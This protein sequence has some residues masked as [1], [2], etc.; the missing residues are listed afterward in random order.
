MKPDWSHLDKYRTQEPPYLSEPGATYGAFVIPINGTHL[1]VIA[2]D[3]DESGDATGQWEHVSTH[4][5]DPVF[6]TVR[7]PKWEE[8]CAVKELFW[9]DNEVV[10]QYHPAKS[11]YVNIHHH[12]LHL[13][14]PKQQQIPTP[15]IACV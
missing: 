7:T 10:L 9:E 12:V 8:M 4:A 15:P 2:T 14:R 5:Y 6:K 1:R 13:W 3:G 11:D